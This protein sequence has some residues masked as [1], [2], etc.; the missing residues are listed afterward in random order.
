LTSNRFWA[1]VA[2]VAVMVASDNGWLTV[3]TA[4]YVITLL[5]GFIGLR[6]IDRFAEKSG[7]VDTGAE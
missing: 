7:S 5:G 6:T 3:T 4:E 1:L 2:L